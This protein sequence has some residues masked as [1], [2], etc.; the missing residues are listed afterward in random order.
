MEPTFF[1]MIVA[2]ILAYVY[3]FIGGFTDAANAIATSV[4]S[5]ALSPMAA[6][7]IASVLEICGALTGTA[8]A[9]TMGGWR[10]IKTLGMKIAPLGTEQGFAAETSAAGVLQLASVLGVPVSTTHTIT[11][12]IV[13][14]GVA[15]RFSSVRWGIAFE[16]ALSW[17]LTL[18]ATVLLGWLFAKIIGL[19][20]SV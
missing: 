12:A 11:S 5:R 2:I 9:L 10:I 14:A 3:A 13:G 8:V 17:V 20:F 15:R 18:P 6:V 7:L 1:L 4:G 19:G 16:I